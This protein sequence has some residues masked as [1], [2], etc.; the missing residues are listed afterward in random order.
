MWFSKLVS[1]MRQFICVYNSSCDLSTPAKWEF[2]VFI[3]SSCLHFTQFNCVIFDY[4]IFVSTLILPLSVRLYLNRYVFHFHLIT[5][6][7]KSEHFN[8]FHGPVGIPV[9]FWHSFWCVCCCC[10]C[11]FFFL[12]L[13]HSGSVLVVQFHVLY[14][15]HHRQ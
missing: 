4:R 6:P 1:S 9:A 3:T 10:Y 11:Y 8:C 5:L 15:H 14:A 13:F 7:M 12:A 2:H